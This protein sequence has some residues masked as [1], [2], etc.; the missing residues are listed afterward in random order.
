MNDYSQAAEGD[1]FVSRSEHGHAG[2]EIRSATP[3]SFREK[4]LSPAPILRSCAFPDFHQVR[5]AFEF[6]GIEFLGEIGIRLPTV[7]S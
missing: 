6:C 7:A 1:G 4:F 2:R 3:E 5:F